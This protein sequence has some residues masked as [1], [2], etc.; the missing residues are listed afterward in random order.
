MQQENSNICDTRIH[1]EETD[2]NGFSW[3]PTLWKK[4]ARGSVRIWS[5][6][7]NNE[8]I[9]RS[10]SAIWKTKDGSYGKVITNNRQMEPYKRESSGTIAVRAKR[11]AGNE[12]KDKRRTYMELPIIPNYV[13]NR[14]Y[15]SLCK[16]WQD[17]K[18]KNYPYLVQPKYDG[19]RAIFRHDQDGV[20]KIYSRT[21]KEY[22]F[23]DHLREQ[24]FTCMVYLSQITGLTVNIAVFDNQHHLS[25]STKIHY[26]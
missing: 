10:E 20:V 6:G 13:D 1:H 22:C 17:V 26:L 4:D 9:K 24:A 14:I 5:V 8:G 7:W 3:L 21:M 12:W 19:N 11:T 2:Q 18:E 25:V 16:R 23:M 15:P